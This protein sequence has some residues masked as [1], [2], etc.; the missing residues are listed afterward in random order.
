MTAAAT[1]PPAASAGAPAFAPPFPEAR[2][3]QS[4]IERAGDSHGGLVVFSTDVPPEAVVEFY[5]QRAEAE[6]LAST[7]N[8]NQ[9]DTRAYGA[10]DAAGDA[11]LSVVASPDGERTSVQLTWSETREP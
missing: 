8:M 11:M 6:G 10:S 9:G 4:A 3:E 2:V 1:P 7:M 5:R